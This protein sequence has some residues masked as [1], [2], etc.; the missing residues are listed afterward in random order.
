M[1][2]RPGSVMM[3]G[4]PGIGIQLILLTVNTITECNIT[5]AFFVNKELAQLKAV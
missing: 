4:M 1:M 5:H 3:G 2:S